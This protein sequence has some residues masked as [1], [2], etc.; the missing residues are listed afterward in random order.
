MKK[1]SHCTGL[2]I[3]FEPGMVV[4]TCNP[5]TAEAGARGSQVQGYPGLQSKLQASL[6]CER[7]PKQNLN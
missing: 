2:N 3:F 7:K 4:H 6:G 1:F 5:S